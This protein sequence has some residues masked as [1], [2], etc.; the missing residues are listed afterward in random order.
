MIALAALK[1]TLRRIGDNPVSAKLRGVSR[2]DTA[3]S[4]AL[5]VRMLERMGASVLRSRAR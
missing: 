2:D 3:L 1:E 4:V 5:V